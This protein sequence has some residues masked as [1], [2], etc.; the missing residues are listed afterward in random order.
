MRLTF[1]LL[2][3]TIN[4]PIEDAT[5]GKKNRRATQRKRTDNKLNES[6]EKIEEGPESVLKENEKNV[7]STE[8]KVQTEEVEAEPQ[9]L[10]MVEV[11]NVTHEK[12]RQTE[13]IKV[14]MRNV[15]RYS[16]K[17]IYKWF[18]R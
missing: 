2:N 6:A 17:I 16:G 5:G 13:E 9:P 15:S 4:V 18:L 3:T 7:G 11:V 10:L 8:Q 12:F 14:I 1:P